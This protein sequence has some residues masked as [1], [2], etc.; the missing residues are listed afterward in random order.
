MSGKAKTTD[1]GNFPSVGCTSSSIEER[2]QAIRRV[3]RN[4]GLTVLG[5]LLFQT[6]GSPRTQP[7]PRIGDVST[8]WSLINA[9]DSFAP[10]AEGDDR[11][12]LSVLGRG[13]RRLTIRCKVEELTF[14]T[15]SL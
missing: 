11:L 3:P 13:G 6:G 9:K 15:S 12:V 14:T 4:L 5:W 10:G 1:G 2:L 7:Y 8:D